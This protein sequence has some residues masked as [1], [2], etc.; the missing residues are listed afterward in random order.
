MKI[1]A[2]RGKNL[3]S[4]STEFVVD[5]QSEP[6]ASA[7]LFAITGPTG[8]GKSTLLD[9]LCLALYERTPRLTGVTR[10]GDIPDV[11]E[12]GITPGDV[13]TI[14]RRG[15]GEGFAEVDFVGGDGVAYRSR[16][17]ARRAR[18]KADGKMQNSEISLIRIV[19]EQV[20]GDRRKTETLPLIESL[21]GLSFEQFTR[22][23]LL[24]QNDFSAFLKASDDDRAELLQTLTGTGTFTEISVQAYERMKVEKEQLQRLQQQL[25]DQEP[26]PTEARTEKDVQFQ[27][28][29]DELKSLTQRQSLLEGHLRWYQ[30]WDLLN[31]A[32]A[33]ATQ[34]LAAATAEKQG[35]TSRYEQLAL[36]DGVQSARPLWVEQVRLQLAVKEAEDA[37]AIATSAQSASQNEVI[38][39]Q[40]AYD[41]ALRQQNAAEAAKAD[42]QP[43]I[44]SAR[45]LDASIVTITP[46]FEAAEKALVDA[47]QRQ[48][49][50]RLRLQEVVS[51]RD[52]AAA[53]LASASQWIADNERWRSLAEG[54]QRWEALFA[55]AQE[56]IEGQSKANA[57]VAELE[58]EVIE[59]E[60]SVSTA[61]IAVEKAISALETDSSQLQALVLECA[62]IDVE[63]LSGEKL[64]LEKDRAQILSATLLWKEIVDTEKLQQK[65]LEQRQ[66]QTDIQA[67]SNTELLNTLPQQPLLE[68]EVHAAEEAL[69]QATLAASANANSLRA[70]LQHEKPCPVCGSLEHPYADDTHM[71]G[72]VLTS[73]KDL[74][75]V[76]RRALS[77]LE[78]RIAGARAGKAAAERSI[79]NIVLELTQLESAMSDL[80]SK[81]SSLT[82]HP[83]LCEVSE[84]ELTQWLEERQ[85][86]VLLKIENVTTQES[87]YREAVKRKDAAQ[88]TVNSSNAMV[89]QTKEALSNLHIKFKAATQSL[90]TARLKHSEI[91]QQLLELEGQLDAAFVGPEWRGRWRLDP[92]EFVAQC[93]ESALAWIEYQT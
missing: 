3:A 49:A 40:T 31:V 59:T 42:A 38:T 36:L 4:L 71:T 76:K 29:S 80:R 69:N 41:E 79:E 11:G 5:F 62:A 44:D 81:W 84:I 23:V 56:R 13:R 78:S 43:D 92:I 28:K 57:R 21:I 53:D 89:T 14:L 52:V 32:E 8:S 16:W 15:A 75:K 87:H 68:R 50:E 2:I 60:T 10:S 82:L 34:Q 45:A 24:A 51:R 55:Q 25:K 35:A 22:A 46:Q 58:N 77:E 48:Q 83:L 86:G 19:D 12:N 27:G 26:L 20:L 67:T 1:L 54:W 64:A 66:Q 91:A 9:A 74:V 93:H 6:L 72:A 17:T 33:E 7:G 39:H 85:D 37:L 88:K 61:G 73:L 18:G 30:Q 47:K 90:D 65:Q 63:K 70:A